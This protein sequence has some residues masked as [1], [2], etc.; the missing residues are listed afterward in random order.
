VPYDLTGEPR[1]EPY[2]NAVHYYPEDDTYTVSDGQASLYAKFTRNGELVWQLGGVE[3]LGD[4]FTLVGLEAWRNNHGHH[5]TSDGR[6]LFFNNGPQF[7]SIPTV[8]EVLLDETEWTATNSWEYV[9][10]DLASGILSDVERLE[11]GNVLVTY[12][13]IGL[14]REVTPDGTVVQSF[15]STSFGYADFRASLY[16][17]P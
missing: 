8:F 4:S 17:P 2:P 12:S 10:D 11:N 14:I 16:G 6:F 3:P 13:P 15:E 5:L 1:T 9:V 7:T